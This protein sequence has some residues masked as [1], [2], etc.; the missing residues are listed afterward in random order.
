MSIVQA[1][2]RY[3]ISPDAPDLEHYV[4]QDPDCFCILVQAIVGP[5][6]QLGEESFDFLVCTPDWIKRRVQEEGYL[7]SRHYLILPLYNYNRLFQIIKD[8]CERTQ[9]PDWNTVATRLGC[10]GL[11]EFEDYTY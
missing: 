9:G 7:L 2:L 8:L 1:E 3:L 5:K 6:N 4:P 11:W 10:Y